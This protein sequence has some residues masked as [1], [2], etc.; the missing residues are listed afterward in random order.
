MA[1]CCGKMYEEGEEISCRGYFLSAYIV[2]EATS[3]YQSR[4]RS[5]KVH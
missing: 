2:E 3:N 1:E 5:W 4:Q